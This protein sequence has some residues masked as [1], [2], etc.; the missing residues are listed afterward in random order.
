MT[1][2]TSPFLAIFNLGP[3]ELIVVFLI[4]LLL[5]GGAKLPGLAKG[6]GQAI[7]EFKKS[8]DDTTDEKPRPSDAKPEA[9]KTHGN[10]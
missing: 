5:F 9:T 7:R 8:K 1:A 3:T 2:V 4:V 6:M 10:N